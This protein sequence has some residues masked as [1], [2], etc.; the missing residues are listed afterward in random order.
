MRFGVLVRRRG[1]VTGAA[2]SV[3]PAFIVERVVLGPCEQGGP[4]LLVRRQGL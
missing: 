4:V 1:D 2:G 3:S